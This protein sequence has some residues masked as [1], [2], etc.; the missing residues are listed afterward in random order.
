MEHSSVNAV[1]VWFYS[2]DTQRYLYLM[3]N[4]ARAES[5]SANLQELEQR[6]RSLPSPLHWCKTA[7]EVAAALSSELEA[8]RVGVESAGVDGAR[9]ACMSGAEL[10]HLAA[11]V[12]GSRLTEELHVQLKRVKE[13]CEAQVA[14]MRHFD[15]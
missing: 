4:D 13:V 6:A 9:L 15:E 11:S 12:G 8:C 2:F 14:T 5:F 7:R 10:L 1:G 3:R